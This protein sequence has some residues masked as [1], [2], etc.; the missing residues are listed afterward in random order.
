V[1]Y[2]ESGVLATS[3][4]FTPGARTAW[5]AHPAGESIYVTE[6]IGYFQRRDESSEVLTRGGRAVFEPG[7][8]HWQGAAPTDLMVQV[9]LISVGADN[10]DTDSC[11][12]V[13]D[14]E[15]GRA[16]GLGN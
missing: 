4:Q 6:G 9:S 12:V 2:I 5:H 14:E 10:H 15:Y 11:D 3:V 7:E 8:E 13:T 1:Q 16:P